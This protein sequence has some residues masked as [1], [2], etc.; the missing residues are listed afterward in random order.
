MHLLKQQAEHPAQ[1]AEQQ[2]GPQVSS[3]KA[4][5]TANR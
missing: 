4:V 5:T 3:I 1:L 2:Q